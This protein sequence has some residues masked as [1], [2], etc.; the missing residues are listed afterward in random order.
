MVGWVL[1]VFIVF[2][3]EFDERG[4]LCSRIVLAFLFCGD[5]SMLLEFLVCGSGEGVFLGFFGFFI[6]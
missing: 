4:F 3:Q 1:S 2:A 5:T 6:G